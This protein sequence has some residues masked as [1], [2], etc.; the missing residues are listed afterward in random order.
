M[1]WHKKTGQLM[2][3]STDRGI[4]VWKEGE[5]KQLLPQLVIIKELKSNLDAQWNHR[6]DKICVGSSS[7]H[8][9][10]GSYNQEVNFWVTPSQTGDKPMHRASVISVCFD[11]GSGHVVAS[12]SAD[13]KV[14]ITSCFDEALDAK[15]KGD[16]PFAQVT[17]DGDTIFEFRNDAWVNFVQ[18]SPSGK[19]LAF[20]SKYS[21]L[22]HLFS[23]RLPS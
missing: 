20:A 1:H 21:H 4:I 15:H 19:W 7:G 12:A 10:V 8:V 16:G 17:S 18:F 3:C 13:G 6:G 2:T 5:G 11:P 14:I 23:K 9:Y 22:T